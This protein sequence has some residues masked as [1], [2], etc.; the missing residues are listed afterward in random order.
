M[1]GDMGY[2]AA[3][4]DDWDE[5]WIWFEAKFSDMAEIWIWSED[6][7]ADEMNLLGWMETGWDMVG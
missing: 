4:T 7:S 5:I 2:L 6:S 1:A 3:E